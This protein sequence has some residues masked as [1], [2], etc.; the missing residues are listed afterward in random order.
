MAPL[1]DC[2]RVTVNED[3]LVVNIVEIFLE[4]I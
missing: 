3:H 1:F 2:S 4:I